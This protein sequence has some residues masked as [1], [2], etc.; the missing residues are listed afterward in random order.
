M[1]S[2]EISIEMWI[3]PLLVRNGVIF[4]LHANDSQR[5]FTIDPYLPNGYDFAIRTT[6]TN[7]LGWPGTLEPSTITTS[8]THLIFTHKN[9]ISKI[10]KNGLEVASQNIGGDIANWNTEARITLANFLSGASPWK[11]IFYLANI[12]NETYIR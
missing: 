3:R 7:D 8:L 6:N 9:G 5:N 4:G 1:E 12:F 2:N 11:G 10:Y